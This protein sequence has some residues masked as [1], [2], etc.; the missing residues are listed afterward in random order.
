MRFDYVNTTSANNVKR[1]N[2][3]TQGI[4]TYLSF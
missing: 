1:H 2:A 3:K 4:E